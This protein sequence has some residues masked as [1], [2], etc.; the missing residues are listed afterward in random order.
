[1][2]SAGRLHLEQGGLSE[3]VQVAGGSFQAGA[4]RRRQPVHDGAQGVVCLGAAGVK[5][6][7][8]IV[9]QCACTAPQAEGRVS[10][11]LCGHCG[12]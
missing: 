3:Q 10:R 9:Q 11:E 4:D 5:H 1:M 6:A 7:P 12:S 2:P 8:G